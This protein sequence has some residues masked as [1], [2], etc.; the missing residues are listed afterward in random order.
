MLRGTLLDWSLSI[1]LV[2][3]VA[4]LDGK[5]VIHSEILSKV[6]RPPL[7]IGLVIGLGV[8]KSDLS[9]PCGRGMQRLPK[10]SS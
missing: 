8:L 5:Y 6:I 3:L 1:V 9:E 10:F 7:D 4:D 2:G